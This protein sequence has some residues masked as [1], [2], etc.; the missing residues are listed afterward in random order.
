MDFGTDVIIDLIS[1]RRFG[2]NE[3]DN[4]DFTQPVMYKT[5]RAHKTTEQIMADRLVADG[6]LSQSEVDEIRQQAQKKLADALEASKTWAPEKQE[7]D[8][9]IATAWKGLAGPND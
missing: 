4:P 5:V 2:H 1:F 6:T 3:V 7:K 8:E 9:W